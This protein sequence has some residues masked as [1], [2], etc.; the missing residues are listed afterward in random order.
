MRQ[1]GGS[2]QPLPNT[3]PLMR[4]DVVAAQIDTRYACE[5][6]TPPIASTYQEG[7][8]GE[9]VGATHEGGTT[10]NLTPN[11]HCDLLPPESL[12]CLTP[13]WRT[14]RCGVQR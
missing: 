3:L 9:V 14:V 5:K 7:A 8:M 12:V 1:K 13:I 6:F 11:D 2:V 10:M 4:Q